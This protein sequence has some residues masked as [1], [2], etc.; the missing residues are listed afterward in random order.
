M[1]IHITWLSVITFRHDRLTERAEPFYVWSPVAM[2]TH[3]ESAGVV[4]EAFYL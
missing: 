2:H 4:T 1:V 3:S